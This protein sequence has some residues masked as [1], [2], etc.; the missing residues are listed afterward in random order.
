MLLSDIVDQIL[1][2]T[3]DSFLQV[4]MICPT[5]TLRTSETLSSQAPVQVSVCVQYHGLDAVQYQ[6]GGQLS[7]GADNMLHLDSVDVRNAGQRHPGSSAG[8][9]IWQNIIGRT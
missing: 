5:W 2:M 1:K 4:L 6:R 7:A 3:A 8:E 9:C